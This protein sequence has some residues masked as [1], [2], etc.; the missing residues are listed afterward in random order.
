MIKTIVYLLSTAGILMAGENQIEFGCSAVNGS[1]LMYSRIT[2]DNEYK[3]VCDLS[4]ISCSYQ[5]PNDKKEES[6]FIDL[7]IFDKHARKIQKDCLDKSLYLCRDFFYKEISNEIK[8]EKESVKKLMD[9]DGS[10]REEDLITKKEQIISE[11]E[12]RL[13]KFSSSISESDIT[14]LQQILG[15]VPLI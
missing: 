5:G 2:A 15:N 3:Y 12:E 9:I 11:K 1:T 13:K 4:C 6:I 14:M 7:D 10:T 8:E